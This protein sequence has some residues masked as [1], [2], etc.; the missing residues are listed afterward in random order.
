MAKKRNRSKVVK[1]LDGVFSIFIRKRHANLDGFTSCVT[2]GKVAHWTKLQNGHFMSR[3]KY[4][5]RWNEK[6]CNVQCSGCN[7]FKQGEQF[8]HSLYIDETYGEGT[9]DELLRLSNTTVKFS[10]PELLE[11]IEHYKD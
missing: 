8:K 3:G 7:M 6:N 4:A 5:T 9:A 1:E 10:T 2:C 11:M